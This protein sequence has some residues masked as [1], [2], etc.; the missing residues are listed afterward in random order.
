MDV[1]KEINLGSWS[2]FEDEV[3]KLF[4]RRK[5]LQDS[6]HSCDQPLFRGLS[7][8][9]RGLE[10]TLERCHPLEAREPITTLPAY[11]RFVYS[12]RAAIETG[13]GKAWED[14]PTPPDF[15]KLLAEFT[16]HAIAP[17]LFFGEQIS[18]YRFF[19]YLRHHGFPSPL[20]DW[21]ASPYVAAFFAFET[22]RE[23]AEYVSV[24]AMMRGRLRVSSPTDA[25]IL[26][27]GPYVRSHAR[28]LVQQSQYTMCVEWVPDYRFQKHDDVI[29]IQKALGKDGQLIKINIPAKDRVEAFRNLDRMNINAFS[30]YGSEDSLVRAVARRE[31]LLRDD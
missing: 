2:E 28:H 10:T 13:T 4:N 26:L 5:E 24:Y 22:M 27:L 18:I 11:Y 31:F 20:L 7:S 3:R 17:Q 8:H 16:G 9:K 12:S 14:I 15:E 21:T 6:G 25:E 19:V 23:D 1:L 29:R 30:L